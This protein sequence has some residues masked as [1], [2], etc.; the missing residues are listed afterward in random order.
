MKPSRT[1]VL[2]CKSM[3]HYWHVDWPPYWSSGRRKR[4]E[5]IFSECKGQVRLLGKHPWYFPWTCRCTSW[6]RRLSMRKRHENNK[7]NR[8][9]AICTLSLVPREMRRISRHTQRF[10]LFIKNRWLLLVVW[11]RKINLEGNRTTTGLAI[12]SL[13]HEKDLTNR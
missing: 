11:Q 9:E 8:L 10:S 6:A 5:N 1:S 7:W 3:I 2:W 4:R 13:Q 12:L